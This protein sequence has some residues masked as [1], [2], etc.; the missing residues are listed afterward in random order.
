MLSQ[1][2]R[3]KQKQQK[4]Q[5]QHQLKPQQRNQGGALP[6]GEIIMDITS[7]KKDDIFFGKVDVGNMPPQRAQEY[8][9]QIKDSFKEHFDNK[10]ILIAVRNNGS[11]R[12]TELEILRGE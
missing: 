5:E 3:R 6:L 1:S 7:I 9:K 10:I 8:V 4:Q 2:R 12:G 11:V